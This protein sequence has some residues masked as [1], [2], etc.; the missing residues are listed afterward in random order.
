MCYWSTR[1]PLSA[2][3]RRRGAGEDETARVAGGKWRCLK[4]QR[5]KFATTMTVNV[6]LGRVGFVPV[7]SL[8]EGAALVGERYARFMKYF[9]S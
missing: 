6:R 4:E 1:A 8:P 3:R 9:G 7:R 5:K 2:R